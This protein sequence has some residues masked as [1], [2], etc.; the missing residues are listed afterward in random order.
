MSLTPFDFIGDATEKVADFA[1]SNSE[2]NPVKEVGIGAAVGAICGTALA[3]GAGAAILPIA[4]TEAA[5][6]GS[7]IIIKNIGKAL[8]DN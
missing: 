5:L 1:E 4:A 7:F 8:F 3:V 6:A 2:G